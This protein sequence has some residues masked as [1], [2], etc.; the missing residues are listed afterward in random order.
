MLSIGFLAFDLD[1]L[2]MVAEQVME[3]PVQQ[4]YL[5]FFETWYRSV[6]LTRKINQDKIEDDERVLRL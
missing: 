5:N 6:L 3:L 2:R 1:I 4:Q